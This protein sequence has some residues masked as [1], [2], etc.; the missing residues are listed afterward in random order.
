MKDRDDDRTAA[1]VEQ[2]VEATRG[3]LDRTVEALKDR[4]TPGHCRRGQPGHGRNGPAVRGWWSR[5]GR[6][7]SLSP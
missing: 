1:E 4:I 7:R 6:T 2:E 5:R 3:N